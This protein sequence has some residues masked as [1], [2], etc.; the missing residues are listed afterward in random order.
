M[1][2]GQLSLLNVSLPFHYL[3][4]KAAESQTL[5]YVAALAF[6]ELHLEPE[7]VHRYQVQNT[8]IRPGTASTG[9]W[10]VLIMCNT[11]SCFRTSTSVQEDSFLCN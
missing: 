8:V 2:S 7:H 10:Q 11:G 1:L 3:F 5:V 6:Q 4:T 9:Y